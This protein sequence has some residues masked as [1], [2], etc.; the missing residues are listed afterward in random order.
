MMMYEFFISNSSKDEV[1]ALIDL[2]FGA[3]NYPF[4]LC[5]EHSDDMEELYQENKLELLSRRLLGFNIE[6]ILQNKNNGTWLIKDRTS[7]APAGC[8]TCLKYPMG[9]QITLISND[10]DYFEKIEQFSLAFFDKA[11]MLG[12]SIEEVNKEGEEAEKEHPWD[13]IPDKNW[14][15]IA[16]RLWWEGFSAKEIS[17]KVYCSPKRIQNRLS[18]LRERYSKDIV[19]TDEIRRRNRKPM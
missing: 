14:D 18:E 6:T 13:K 17:E 5:T 1:D 3:N 2:N 15:R 19:P 4:N 16:V 8:I 11:K 7:G 12:Y 10:L 9:F